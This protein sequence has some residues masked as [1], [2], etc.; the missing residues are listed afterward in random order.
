MASFATP[1]MKLRRKLV[2]V[3]SRG[4]G[5]SSLLKRYTEGKFDDKYYPTIETVLQKD[6]QY[7]GRTFQC[8]IYDTAGQDEFSILNTRHSLGIH[9]YLLV[10]ALSSRASF[11]LLPTIHA[12]I[13][14]YTGTEVIPAVLIGQK[15][16]LDQI[17]QVPAADAQALAKDLGVPYIE[18]SALDN[19]N[20]GA[21]GSIIC[22]LCAL[23]TVAQTRH[24]S[25]LCRKARRACSPSRPGPRPRLRSRTGACSCEVREPCTQCWR[26]P[27]PRAAPQAPWA[28]LPHSKGKRPMLS[29]V[30]ACR[31]G[32]C[33]MLSRQGPWAR[34]P[35]S[36]R[37]VEN[38]IV[39]TEWASCRLW[40]GRGG[41]QGRGA[42]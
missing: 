25:W 34:W 13:T 36:G 28:R 41:A 20:V 12:K 31:H 21:Y 5:K 26:W 3:G 22:H 23:T 38:A 8:E 14:D 15:S 2:I 33:C 7:R 6:I 19:T 30:R 16:D 11:D 10:F 17:R 24:S 29:R 39:S 40:R 4:V 27:G 1:E 18:V 42:P 35:G 37:A 9:A 32:I